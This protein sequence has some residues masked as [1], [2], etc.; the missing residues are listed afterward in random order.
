MN[1]YRRLISNTLTFGIGTFS[2]KVLVFLLMPLYTRILTPDQYSDTELITNMAN[3]LMPIVSVG[4]ISSIMRFGLDRAYDKQSVFT[5]GILTIGSG[6]AIYLLLLPALIHVE[7]IGKYTMLVTLY[8]IM[9]A[10]KSLM[11]NFVRALQYVKLFAFDG[12]LSTIMTIIFNIFFLV[13]FHWGV[14]GY[15]LATIAADFCSTI[16]LF[17]MAS[18]WRYFSLHKFDRGL[19]KSMLRY[20]VPLIPTSLSWWITNVSS[21]YIVAAMISSEVNGL[22]SVAFKIPNLLVLVSTIFTEAWQMTAITEKD[23]ADKNVFFTKVFASF[24]SLLFI[25]SSLIICCSKIFTKLLTSDAFYDSWQYIPLLVIA[26]AFSCFSNFFGSVYMVEKKSMLTLV[27]V[28][29]G[30]ASNVA[31]NFLLIPQMGANGAALAAVLSYIILFLMRVFTSRKLIRI[32]INVLQM[33]LNILLTGAQAYVMIMEIPYWVV[34]QLVL[35]VAMMAINVK[36]LLTGAKR[37]LKR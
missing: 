33:G 12:V 3:L 10:L 30:A 32:K 31:L 26:T 25:A 27:T 20:C 14:N 18:L 2:S 23:S 7:I 13:V 34:I 4:I 22:Y 9:S 24:Q 21:K 29:T 37:I 8:V 1:R 6:F 5:T 19:T 28:M 16:F 11:S 15:V 35:V 17:F 36:P